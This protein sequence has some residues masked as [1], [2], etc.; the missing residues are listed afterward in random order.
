LQLNQ[1][2]M[3]EAN[4]IGPRERLPSS[5]RSRVLLDY[6]ASLK[7]TILKNGVKVIPSEWDNGAAIAELCVGIRRNKGRYIGH[8]KFDVDLF[9]DPT[10]DRLI[11]HLKKTLAAVFMNPELPISEIEILTDAEIELFRQVNQTTVE[12]KTLSFADQAFCQQV[13]RTPDAPAVVCNGQ[14]WSYREL[15]DATFRIATSLRQNG[16]RRHDRV[17][18]WLPRGANSVAAMLA[19]M[20]CGAAYVP[21]DPH[22]PKKRQKLILDSADVR[23]VVTTSEQ[24]DFISA[25]TPTV[26]VETLKHSPSQV[27]CDVFTSIERAPA[28]IAYVLFTSGST[29]QPKGVEVTHLNVDNFFLGM[30]SLQTTEAGCW[31]A[32]TNV[33]FDISVF[34]QLWTIS[35]GFKVVISSGAE[36][37]GDNSIESLAKLFRDHQ[38]THLQCTPAMMQLLLRDTET[39]T[40]IS[41]LRQIFVGGDVMPGPLANEL[42]SQSSADIFNMYGPTET[43]VWSTSWKLQREK[44]IRIG[45]PLPNQQVHVLDEFLKPTPLGV[46]G[47]LFIAGQGVAR[48]YHRDGDL[49]DSR[50]IQ[51]KNLGRMFRTGDTVKMLPDGD[52][53][54]LGRNDQQVKLHGHRI[55]L[56]E[57]ELA[58]LQYPDIEQAVALVHEKDT[59]ARLVVFV[60]GSQDLELKLKEV[61]A[62]LCERL[63]QYMVPSDIFFLSS[64]PL[65]SAG[66][67]DRNSLLTQAPERS[68][69]ARLAD[70]PSIPESNGA[71]HSRSA[72]T[73]DDQRMNQL[74]EL[75]REELRLKSLPPNAKWSDLAINSLEVVGLVVR[76]EH[77]MNLSLP[78][79]DIFRHSYVE[80]TLRA[81]INTTGN[82][83]P[84][85][86]EA[87]PLAEIEEGVI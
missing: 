43:T 8:V 24:L 47:E 6:Q 66:K 3:N 61:E 79:A 58:I 53:V 80:E 25:E 9:D 13:E 18:I 48:G 4:E 78:V 15:Q 55:E 19:T 30:D 16:I 34:E 46:A 67:I 65:N 5:T 44:T 7:T 62:F 71:T 32:V 57:I 73:W 74:K 11:G 22:S 14:N 45:K 41:K 76:V 26:D 33:A 50:F 60:A 17:A 27:E 56:G 82:R 2:R 42:L 83:P 29:G 40:G 36:P 1:A 84:I 85:D 21:I 31:L 23:C 35:R 10:V 20:M 75:I 28:D 38:V 77:E 63:P 72:E 59:N 69:A 37:G 12:A 49:T 52:L 87:V 81:A 70:V 51:H 68:I 39:R 86:V 64:M 54:F